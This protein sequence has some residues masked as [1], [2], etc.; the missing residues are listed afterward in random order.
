VGFFNQCRKCGAELPVGSLECLKC[1]ALVEADRLEQFASEARASE[2]RGDLMGARQQWLMS[3]PLLPPQSKQA[4]LIQERAE[5]LQSRA[6]SQGANSGW[7]KKLG[8]VG[9]LGLL[10]LK[11]KGLI[12]AVFK[13]KFLFSLASFIGIYW[14]LYGA[15]FGIGFALSILVHEM[16]H[17]IDVKRRGLPAE[18]PVFL[19][20]FGAYVKWQAMGVS[21]ATRAEVSLAGP[22]AGLCAAAFCAFLWLQTGDRL[23]AALAY[24]GAWLNV[25][26]LIPVWMLDGGHAFP[27]LSRTNRSVVLVAAVGLWYSFGEATLLLVAAGATWRLFTKDA[28]A[29]SDYRTTAYFLAVLSLLALL[30]WKMAAVGGHGAYR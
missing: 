9:V 5:Q 23:W 27:A 7:T 18:M 10:A 8:P 12:F 22:L 14:A 26:N 29:E 15:K 25:L 20:G 1:H 2:K 28:P 3:L 6:A 11:F 16:G 24:A 30:M 4:K 19:P 21:A 17:Y 13:L